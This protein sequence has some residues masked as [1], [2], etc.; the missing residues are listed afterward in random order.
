MNAAAASA[1]TSRHQQRARALEIQA[2]TIEEC[3]RELRAQVEARHAHRYHPLAAQWS[4]RAAELRETAG[5]LR[6][7]SQ[8]QQEG[9]AA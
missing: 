4:A 7:E 8:E 2:N 5:Q 6:E 3:A 9:A 1:R